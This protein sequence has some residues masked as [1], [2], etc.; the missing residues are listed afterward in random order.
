MTRSVF[1]KAH[2]GY[3]VVETEKFCD[4]ARFGRE[5]IGMHVDDASED[6]MRF[7][8]DENACRFL[9]RRGPAEDVTTL[10][11]HL[12]DDDTFD[13]VMARVRQHGVPVVEGTPEES[14]LR[15]VE[16]LVRF[17]GPN[18]LTQEIF[19]RARVAATPLQAVSEF[20]TGTGGLGHVAV[21]T[22]RPHRQR[23]EG[24][25]R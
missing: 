17:P 15:G 1:G 3:L 12:D 24:C 8:L 4:W 23:A 25:C 22:T 14:A 20:V 10:G 11:W 5:A 6:T 13:A 2:L 7:R 9:L 18:G 16:R 21:P 19:T